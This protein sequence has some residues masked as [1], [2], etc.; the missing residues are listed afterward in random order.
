MQKDL[1]NDLPLSELEEQLVYR[2]KNPEFLMTALSHRSYANEKNRQG[3]DSY[4]NNERLEYLGDAVLDLALSEI[5][6]R[7]E[8]EASEGFLSKKR[9]SLVNEASLNEI[10]QSLNLSKYVLL[11]RGERNSGGQFKP[12]LLACCVEAIIGAIFKDSNYE[13]AK[14]VVVRLYEDLLI[15]RSQ[16]DAYEQDYKTRFQEICQ[17][18]YMELPKYEITDAIGPAHARRFISEVS[19][20]GRWLSRGQGTSKKIAEQQAARRAMEVIHVL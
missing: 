19:L 2:F 17:Q 7:I 8:P 6:M 5:L 14:K 16:Q 3:E 9:A 1:L 15:H 12:R 13:T 11:G 4:Q 10:A 20:A 18:K